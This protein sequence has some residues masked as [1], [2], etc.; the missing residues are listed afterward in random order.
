MVFLV[1]KVLQGLGGARP[2]VEA[3]SAP[4]EVWVTY[5]PSARGMFTQPYDN[6]GTH[7]LLASVAEASNAEA[8]SCLRKAAEEI[9]SLRAQLAEERAARLRDESEHLGVR[10]ELAEAVAAL[11]VAEGERLT[12]AKATR[13]F[14]GYVEALYRDKEVEQWFKDVVALAERIVAEERTKEGSDNG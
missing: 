11:A 10:H 3:L 14:S 8:V 1:Q 6:G 5:F 9:D 4:K 2:G 12:L 7:Y 13:G